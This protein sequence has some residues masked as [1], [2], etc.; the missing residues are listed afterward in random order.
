MASKLKNEV[1]A[2]DAILELKMDST[3]KLHKLNEICMIDPFTT[4]A[5]EVIDHIKTLEYSTNV[6]PDE[7]SQE[8]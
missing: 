5:E 3:N 4:S 2:N 1:K 8:L 6:Y 7:V